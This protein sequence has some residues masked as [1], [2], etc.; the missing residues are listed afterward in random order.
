VSLWTLGTVMSEATTLIGNRNDIALSRASFYANQ[1]ALDI[2]FAVEPQDMEGIAVASTTSGENKI[3]LPSDF[4]DIL[5][6]SNLS[7][8]PP[9]LLTKW[10]WYDVDS[11]DTELGTPTNYVS[12]SSYLQLWPSPDSSY[13]I[14]LRYQVRP[15][16]LTDTTAVPSFDTR[17]G[18]AWLYKTAEYLADSVKDYETAG[19]MRNKY[20]AALATVPSDLALRQ[21]DRTGQ[22]IRFG[23]RPTK[24]RFLEFDDSVGWP[25]SIYGP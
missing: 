15:S 14:Q 3:S 12:Y 11:T 13:S 10:N 21:R 5:A 23:T 4:Y 17:F 16:V 2:N 19:M 18:M 9:Q 25:P 7:I 8:S 1:A 20:L 24:E 6:M 22:N